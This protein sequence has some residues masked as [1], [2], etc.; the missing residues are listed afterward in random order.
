MIILGSLR[1]HIGLIFGSLHDHFGITSSAFGQ[2]G[3]IRIEASTRFWRV[4]G[5][6]RVFS[7]VRAARGDSYGGKRSVLAG[8]GLGARFFMSS[9]SSGRFV[10]RLALGFGG[11][12]GWMGAEQ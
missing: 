2:L 12:G 6:E 5:L 4:R 3:E 10:W 7:S 1:D 9:G 11:F 8:S